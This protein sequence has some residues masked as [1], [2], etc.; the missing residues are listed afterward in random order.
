LYQRIIATLTEI[1]DQDYITLDDAMIEDLAHTLRLVVSFW[2]SYQH[3]QSLTKITQSTISKGVL[4]VLNIVKGYLTESG[5]T[6][7]NEIEKNYL[8][9]TKTN[10]FSKNMD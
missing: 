1:R 7:I 10:E 5:L 8:A 2:V 6:H 3:T 4:K 9:M